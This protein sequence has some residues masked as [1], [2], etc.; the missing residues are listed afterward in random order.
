MTYHRA[1]DLLSAQGYA[2]GTPNS[3]TGE[4]RIWAPGGTESVEVRIGRELDDLAAGKLT[5][6]QICERRDDEVPSEP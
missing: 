4:V 1:L 6:E 3:Q 2:V 5:L